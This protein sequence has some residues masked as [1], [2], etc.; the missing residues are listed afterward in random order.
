MRETDVEVILER[1][2][3]KYRE[4]RYTG[5]L[6]AGVTFVSATATQGS[7]ISARDIAVP[8]LP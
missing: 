7:C 6:P 1:T 2:K 8:R 5:T 3:E 4:R